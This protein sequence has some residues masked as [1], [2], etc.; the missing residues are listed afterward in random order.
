MAPLPPNAPLADIYAAIVP[1]QTIA[2]RGD[3]ER[4]F[5]FVVT[6]AE[7]LHYAEWDAI[8][9]LGT[10]SRHYGTIGTMHQR[11][12]EKPVD[13]LLNPDLTVHHINGIESAWRTRRGRQVLPC[14]SAGRSDGFPTLAEVP[15]PAHG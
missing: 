10:Y 6:S 8:E 1:G 7:H 11:E 12:L 13:R 2:E 9:L 4:D 5:R 3:N 15:A 14:A